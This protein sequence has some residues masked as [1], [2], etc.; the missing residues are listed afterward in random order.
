MGLFVNSFGKQY[1]LVSMDNVTKW[2]EE[3]GSPINDHKV[4]LEILQ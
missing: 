3:I 2:V 1:T 4:A